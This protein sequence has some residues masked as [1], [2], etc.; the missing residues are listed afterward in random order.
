M[1]YFAVCDDEK[2]FCETV[3]QEL[4]DYMK[5]TDISYQLDTY[6][7]TKG[8]LSSEINYDILFMDIE[9]KNEP[10]NAGLTAAEQYAK[11]RH[12][13][14]ILLTSHREEMANGYKIRAFRFLVKPIQK[15]LFHEALDSALQA[16]A[17]NQRIIVY[18]N[19]GATS[20]HV[21]D[22][23]YAEAEHKKS[24]IRTA[25]GIY[26]Y[27]EGITRLRKILENDASFFM[28]HKSYLIN[29]NYVDKIYPS[30]LT[31]TICD[32]KI[33][34]SR[35]QNKAFQTHYLNYIRKRIHQN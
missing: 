13:L 2:I 17:Q 4:A 21:S 27:P 1:V 26:T 8:L 32:E 9:F 5:D 16:L 14:T 15:E 28:P 25:D 3:K 12:T 11:N 6:N 23:I 7:T 19:G 33:P 22:I 30:V 31:F 20:I 35:L 29:M 18:H 34:I 24:L 10:N